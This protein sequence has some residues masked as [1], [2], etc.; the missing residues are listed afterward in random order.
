MTESLKTILPKISGIFTI[1]AIPLQIKIYLFTILIMMLSFVKCVG[2][3]SPKKTVDRNGFPYY[4]IPM[5]RF[6]ER[7]E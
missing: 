1:T 2:L 7:V 3:F 4:N 6:A 5:N